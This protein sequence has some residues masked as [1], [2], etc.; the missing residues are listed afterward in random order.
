MSVRF[1]I[2]LS[3]I[4]LATGVV[5]LSPVKLPFSISAYGKIV[6]AKKW[7]L[8]KGT[9]GQ[10]T[11]SSFNYE[12]GTSEGYT[13]SQFAREGA[14]QFAIHP[15]ILSS[16]AAASGD[17]VGIISSSETE[18]QM[19]ELT[20]T[21]MTA[22]ANLE[23]VRGGEK[24]SVIHECRQRLSLARERSVWQ[25]KDLVRFQA[26]HQKNLISPAT[27]DSVESEARL[28]DIEVG[29]AQAQLETALTGEKP[30]QIEML[31]SQI[32]ALEQEIL[33]LHDRIGSFSITA[34]FGGKVS[35][36]FAS[37]TIMIIS[38]TSTMLALIPVDYRIASIVSPGQEV[39]IKPDMGSSVIKGYLLPLDTDV[40]ILQ[41]RQVLLAVVQLAEPSNEILPGMMAQCT[42]SCPPVPILDYIKR[43][44][45]SR[46]M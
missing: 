20:G 6:P 40:R 17:T 36:S 45:T 21:L 15:K 46:V 41:D 34:P 35:R 4:A 33:S 10:L 12:S 29:I 30:K 14:M 43:F 26:L 19:I 1:V 44:F 16:G 7:V 27:L 9:D 18:E 32:Q 2:I 23:A 39:Q 31:Q 22:K 5:A 11:T 28:L 8:T 25:Q 13:V 3:A 24:E 42:V 37:D 38:D